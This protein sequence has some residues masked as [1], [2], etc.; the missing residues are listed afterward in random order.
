MK[1]SFRKL[2]SDD[3][4]VE[5][6]QLEA[7]HGMSSSDFYERFRAGE[8]GDS[9]EIVHWANLCYTAQRMGILQRQST[10]V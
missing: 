6:A 5:L 1:L 2:T 10:R 7:R 9:D 4:R 3:L 8:V